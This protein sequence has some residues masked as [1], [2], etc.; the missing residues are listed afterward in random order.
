MVS[1]HKVFYLRL[2]EGIIESKNLAVIKASR[3]NE[4]RANSRD[5]LARHLG[6]RI[7]YLYL[8]NVSVSPYVNNNPLFWGAIIGL[9]LLMKIQIYEAG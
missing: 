5:C 6:F 4:N 3:N 1:Q 2:V 9:V 7:P 8:N